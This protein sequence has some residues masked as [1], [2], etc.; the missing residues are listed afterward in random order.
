VNVWNLTG[1][2][3]PGARNGTG[4][5]EVAKLVTDSRLPRTEDVEEATTRS[6]AANLMSVCE[7]TPP[8]VIAEKGAALSAPASAAGG[9]GT[10][11]TKSLS[12]RHPTPRQPRPQ[13]C[14]HAAGVAR[15][16]LGQERT[17]LRAADT[18]SDR[19]ESDLSV[20]AKLG[21]YQFHLKLGLPYHTVSLD[22]R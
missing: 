18:V 17:A 19:F 12:R 20:V 15:T 1:A 8:G 4:D 14:G 13:H 22:W 16:W 7:G 2:N 21:D 10:S 6:Q 3:L 5:G 9:T 11:M